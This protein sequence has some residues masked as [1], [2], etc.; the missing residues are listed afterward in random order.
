MAN[1]EHTDII[2]Q[3]VRAW[4]KWRAENPTIDPDLSN[5]DLQGINLD[6]LMMFS[7]TGHRLTK[8]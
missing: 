1:Q 6:A 2:K 5:A 4:N 8:L 7:E 3:G